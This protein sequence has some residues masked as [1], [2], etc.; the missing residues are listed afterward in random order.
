MTQ[1]AR[2]LRSAREAAED[3]LAP[4]RPQTGLDRELR[5]AFA[6]IDASMAHMPSRN[7]ARNIPDDPQM[8]GSAAFDFTDV[9]RARE[10]G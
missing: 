8:Q 3:R 5:D 10:D 2:S 7:W 4:G 9:R 1:L 6:K